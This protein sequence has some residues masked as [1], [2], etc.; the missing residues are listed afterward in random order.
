MVLAFSLLIVQPATGVAL[1]P[2][3]AGSR[4]RFIPERSSR[5]LIMTIAVK[6]CFDLGDLES[7]A[8]AMYDLMVSE[9]VESDL[10]TPPWN[11]SRLVTEAVNCVAFKGKP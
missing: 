3:S 8:K 9:A 5:A 2:V 10:R 1:P 4:Y 11:R 6:D 7:V